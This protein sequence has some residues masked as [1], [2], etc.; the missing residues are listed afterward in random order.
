MEEL[1]GETTIDCKVPLNLLTVRTVFPL[2][3][4]TDALIV[5][6]PRAENAVASPVALIF[7]T[8][9]LEEFQTT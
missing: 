6:E 5:D 3:E 7:A 1:A 8:L 9:G 4:P 2:T